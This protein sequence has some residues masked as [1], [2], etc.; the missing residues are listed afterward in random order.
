LPFTDK[1]KELAT[2][3]KNKNIRGLYGGIKEFKESY[4]PRSNLV[5]DENDDLLSDSKDIL[6][7]CKN[8][9][10]QLLNMHSVNEVRQKY[11]Q[12]NH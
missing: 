1:I 11:I 8:Y 6:N 5:K 2:N 4:Q 10:C 7:V 12:L 9:F 3:C